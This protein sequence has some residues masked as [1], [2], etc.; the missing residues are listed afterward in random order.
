MPHVKRENQKLTRLQA[1]DVMIRSNRDLPLTYHLRRKI[2]DLYFSKVREA[3]VAGFTWTFP[4]ESSISIHTEK[5][6][7]Q[8]KRKAAEDSIEFLNQRTI[9]YVRGG[10]FDIGRRYNFSASDE[11]DRL[12]S[13]VLETK[14]RYI[15]KPIE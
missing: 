15:L 8:H 5:D 14:H 12:I 9:V 1:N 11:L 7:S 6:Y 13:K 2:F 4:D 10:F 3:I